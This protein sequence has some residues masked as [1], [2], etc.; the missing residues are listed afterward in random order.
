MITLTGQGGLVLAADTW[1][2]PGDPAVILLHGGGQ[3]RHAWKQAG[4]ELSSSGFHVIALD[5][6]GHG[7]SEWAIDGDYSLRTMVADLESVV[8]TLPARPAIVGASIGG[9]TALLAAGRAEPQC[10]AVVVVDIVPRIERSGALRIVSFMNGNPDGFA[11]I[12]Q[13]ADAIANYLPERPRPPDLSG[14]EKNLRRT[15]D[16]R[17]R[18]HWDPK[19]LEDPHGRMQERE[20]LF[21][22]AENLAIPTLLIRGQFSDIVSMAGVEEFLGTVPHAE[23]VDIAG[24]SHMVAGDSNDVFSQAVCDFLSRTLVR[25]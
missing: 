22:A 25:R 20:S 17:Y 18:W 9:S 6:R 12:E 2:Q 7:D 14:L 21:G 3:T 13:A 8:D 19:F 23:F 16:G 15:D 10:S 24:A 11:S 4:A 1:G 5:L